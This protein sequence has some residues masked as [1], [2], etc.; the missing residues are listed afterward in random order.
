LKKPPRF[1]GKL[2]DAPRLKGIPE[3]RGDR[4]RRA[5]SGAGLTTSASRIIG[6]IPTSGAPRNPLRAVV[7]QVVGADIQCGCKGVQVGVH[8]NLRFDVGLATPILGTLPAPP[9]TTR[10]LYPLEFVI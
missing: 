4:D 9:S 7:E 3:H 1:E 2:N 5:D 6:A 8:E 10:Q